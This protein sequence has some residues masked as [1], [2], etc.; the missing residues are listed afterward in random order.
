M[1]FVMNRFLPLSIIVSVALWAVS[2][3]D[4]P[5]GKELPDYS[6]SYT[7]KDVTFEMLKAPAGNLTMGI[8]ADNRRKVTHGIAQPVALDGFVISSQP[9]SQA[10]WTAVMGN[11][12]SQV[13]YPSAPVDMVS[14]VDIQKFLSKLGK[15]TGKS[16][17]LPTEA[18]WE[19]SYKLFGDKDFTAVAEWC[20][21]NYDEVPAD[22][23]SDDYFKPMN[24][25]VNPTGPEKGSAKVVRTTLER[26][27][28][29]SHTRR[30]KVG[31]RLAQPTEEELTEAIIGPLDSAKVYRERIDA[32]D[33]VPEFFTVGD[34]RF[35]M[36]KIPGG[37]FSM[38]FNPAFDTPYLNFSVPDNE[39]NVHQVTVDD[40]EIGETEVTVGLWHKVMGSVPYLNDISEP[41]KP[42]GNVSWYDC[43]VFLRKLNELTGRTFR[44]P[45]EAEWE[46]AAR[47]GR[48][49][50]HF[51]FSGSNDMK[52]VMWF[53]DNA[54]SK[55]HA[56]KTKKPNELGL[57]DMSGNVW[58]WCYDRAEEYTKEA[59]VNPCGAQ[60]GGTR[61][62]RGGCCASRWDA[63]RI[64][65]RSYMPGKNFKGTFGLRLAL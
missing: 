38:G 11:N 56:V 49:S 39:V 47:G 17:F 9:V 19:Y 34:V 44:L 1:V 14:W 12:P 42:V 21:D 65:N 59:R 45:T 26:M 29:E 54:D 51:G 57:Y 6:M 13:K 36:V 20:R 27:P 25:M 60:T 52:S 40:F 41:D 31:F 28:I 62:L 63:C 58:E 55:P 23:T 64:S 37:D 61:F 32:S 7:V 22:V 15:A 30:V 8:S 4:N 18:Q 53:L 43:Q 16:F 33:G 48:M 10:L 5:G 35:K 24:L 2:C 46:Y 3:G 50:R